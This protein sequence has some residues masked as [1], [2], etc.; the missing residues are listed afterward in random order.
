MKK[1]HIPEERFRLSADRVRR[2]QFAPLHAPEIDP[3]SAEPSWE[4]Y[5]QA[6]DKGFDEGVTKGHEAGLVSGHEEGLQKGYASGFNQG[7]IE[8]Q[9]KGKDSID[10]QLNSIMAPLSAMKSLLEEGHTQQVMQQQDLILE[11]VRRVSIQVIRCELTLQPQQ[12]L[13]LVEETL[14]AIPDDPTEVKIHLEPSAVTKLRE[15]AA[16]KIQHWTL[17]ADSNISAGG[18]R[19]LS[20]KSDADASMETRLNSC[21]DQ[22]ESHLKSM[23][24]NPKTSEASVEA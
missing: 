23:P 2:H 9:Q 4:D 16:D 13:A 14:A 17:V 21:L 15:L 3:N 8:G 22:V 1:T 11:L 24:I 18:C 20:D 10:E 7:R 19:I 6:F 5:Q 12:I